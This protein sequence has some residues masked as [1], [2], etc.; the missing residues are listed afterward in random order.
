MARWA[1]ELL[2]E[3]SFEVLLVIRLLAVLYASVAAELPANSRLR[4]L[5]KVT[6]QVAFHR[7]ASK[8]MKLNESEDFFL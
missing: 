4:Y 2:T 1:E 3:I 8:S 7:E 6:G 5:H